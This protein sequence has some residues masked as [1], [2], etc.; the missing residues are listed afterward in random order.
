[1]VRRTALDYA[2]WPY[3]RGSETTTVEIVRLLLDAGARLVDADFL[4]HNACRRGYAQVVDLLISEANAD[5]HD[6]DREGN[7][8]M[9]CAIRAGDNDTDIA[10]IVGLLLAGAG[11][12]AN[13]SF[14]ES[15]YTALQI[16]CKKGLVQVVRMLIAEIPMD[17]HAIGGRH[18]TAML[19]AVNC[20][21]QSNTAEIV[22]ILLSAGVNA[23]AIV[24]SSTNRTALFYADTAEV[25]YLLIG[26]GAN[27]RHIDCEGSSALHLACLI[28]RVG[29]A[30]V[31]LNASGAGAEMV[32]W[33][34]HCGCTPL[35]EATD[36][37]DDSVTSVYHMC[38]LLHSFG[39]DANARNNDMKTPLHDAANLCIQDVDDAVRF[40][41]D[42]MNA[43]VNVKDAS[44][45]TPLFLAKYTQNIMRFLLDKGADLQDASLLL[46]HCARSND[47]E[48]VE[49]LTAAGAD[50]TV[51]GQYG[52]NAFDAA[53]HRCQ[54][55]DGN[56]H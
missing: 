4:L 34:D 49:L 9:Y 32:H 2:L 39:A 10:K 27:V 42:E 31:L 48:Q 33:K 41:V 8:A 45:E 15:Y 46:N 50:V 20:S 3:G 24:E 44:G 1:V 40:L 56:R 55:Y 11:G 18:Q 37:S 51:A 43:D 38:R 21:Q 7:T 47:L 23:D 13:A 30:T 52:L 35:H 26:A 12:N 36:G 29:V 25:A 54:Y 53:F 19:D 5:V 16:A 22:Q 14:V 28:K 17:A 6:T